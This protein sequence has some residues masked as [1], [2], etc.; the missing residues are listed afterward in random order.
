M[1]PTP[2]K[3]GRHKQG[4]DGIPLTTGRVTIRIIIKAINEA[5]SSP[6]QM[7]LR[8]LPLTAKIFLAGLLSRIRRSGINENIMADVIEDAERL[9]RMAPSADLVDLVLGRESLLPASAKGS[10]GLLLTPRK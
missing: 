5:T 10:D 2:S 3:S 7:C 1:P 4:D 6:L 9:V 8:H